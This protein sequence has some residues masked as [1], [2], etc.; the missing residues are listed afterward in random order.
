LAPIV[1][2]V[3]WR[4]NNGYR[5]RGIFS[6]VPVGNF[7]SNFTHQ[8]ITFL[9]N[10]VRDLGLENTRPF[11]V[12][13]WQDGDRRGLYRVVRLRDDQNYPDVHS[14]DV[15]PS[16]EFRAFLDSLS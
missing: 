2:K 7:N 13:R 10:K 11:G 12:L 1:A 9:S 4:W 14:S 8:E 16:G 5:A 6:R 3:E 15:R